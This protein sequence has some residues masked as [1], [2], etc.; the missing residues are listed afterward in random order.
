[1]D[2][3]QKNQDEVYSRV[4][5]LNSSVNQVLKDLQGSSERDLS[6]EL[7]SV[8][9]HK[10]GFMRSSE[11]AS[12]LFFSSLHVF[13]SAGHVLVVCWDFVSVSF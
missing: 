5:N 9:Q 4:K 11:S 3:I 12:Q 6:G 2:L 13:L 10:S 1:M 8:S 7:F